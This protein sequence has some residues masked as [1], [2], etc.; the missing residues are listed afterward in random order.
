MFVFI[1]WG[2]QSL[3][4]KRSGDFTEQDPSMNLVYHSHLP[5]TV[6]VAAFRGSGEAERMVLELRSKGEEAYWQKSDGE[7]PWYRV[8]IGG[9]AT[10][11][12]AKTH[13]E[14]LIKRQL[15]E[16]YYIA[17]FVDGYYRNP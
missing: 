5:F 15:I 7:K 11:A 1:V 9:F 17:N 8:R 14:D 2:I 4:P 16:N 10:Q 6:Q 12:V 13:A 3:I